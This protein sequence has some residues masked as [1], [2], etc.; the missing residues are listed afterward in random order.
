MD[1]RNLENEP[2]AVVISIHLN[3]Y[4]NYYGK[5]AKFYLEYALS[6]PHGML[7]LMD[8]DGKSLDA[9]QAATR[10]IYNLQNGFPTM[11]ISKL[12]TELYSEAV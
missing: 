6:L 10:L 5:E 3:N 9:A 7:E 1:I 11:D 4:L 8:F 2:Y 12:L